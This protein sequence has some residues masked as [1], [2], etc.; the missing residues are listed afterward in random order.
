MVL[1][2]LENELLILDKIEKE[3]QKVMKIL[4]KNLE[5]DLLEIQDKINFVS[6][7]I[8]NMMTIAGKTAFPK[9]D[10]MELFNSESVEQNIF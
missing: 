4:N 1:K 8:D 5:C 9:N 6:C 10:E 3:Q 2:K 7:N